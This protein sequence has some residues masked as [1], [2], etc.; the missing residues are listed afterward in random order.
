MLPVKK[1][2]V[3]NFYNTIREKFPEIT[4]K[5][6]IK[7]IEIWSEVDPEFAYSWFESLANALNSEMINGV[8]ANKYK[9]LFNY[10]SRN[11]DEGNSEVRDCIDVSFTES[12]FWKVPKNKAK[13]YWKSLPLNL[14][15][16][17]INFHRKE[18]F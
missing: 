14:R 8:N 17:Y 11:F 10:I 3:L 4:K 12:L 5:T 13:I 6:D 2:S 1:M 9:E 16:L 15:T 18:P 7:H